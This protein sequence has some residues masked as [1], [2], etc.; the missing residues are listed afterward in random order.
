M[1]KANSALAML[2]RQSLT[3][4]EPE[5]SAEPLKIEEWDDVI[6]LSESHK[7]TGLL[8]DTVSRRGDVPD[9]VSDAVRK[10]A[11]KTAAQDFRLLFLSRDILNTF[12]TSG[13][14]AVLLKGMGTAS[15][16]TNPLSRKSGDVDI[17]IAD[18]ARID[19][20]VCLLEKHGFKVKERQF[21]LHHIV[22]VTDDDI[23]IELHTMLAEPFDNEKVN[24]LLRLQQNSLT[25]TDD[26][27]KKILN[28]EF[29]KRIDVLGAGLTVLEDA[30]H[31]YELLLHML[32]HYLR[33]GF[34]IRLLC[35]WVVFWNSVNSMDTVNRYLWL[36]RNSGIKGFSDMITLE[37]YRYLGLKKACAAWLK[38]EES[39]LT[40]GDIDEFWNEFISYGEF[41][42]GSG[43]RMVAL[44]GNGLFDYLREFQHQM[45]LNY[46]RESRFLLIRPVLYLITLIRF[47]INNRKVRST[48]LG[49]VL[50]SAGQR[51]KMINKL[52][53]FS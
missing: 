30:Y 48:S 4:S 24:S 47:L 40:K 32:Q 14:P 42:K 19:E 28:N 17:L 15:F 20:A 13:I 27:G 18:E 6:K 3:S 23:D 10:A 33:S 44:R 38:P 5:S 51:G 16:Y 35:D 39:K 45:R 12:E 26:E 25:V 7:V 41:G 31:A 50:K 9:T 46:P 52:K 53:L 22:M 2:L 8:F 21:A 11:L 49:A 34:G 43:D 29:V 36:V 1:D 37:C